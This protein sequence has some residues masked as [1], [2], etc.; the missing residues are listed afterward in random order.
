MTFPVPQTSPE[1]LGSG[2][3]SPEAIMM[4]EQLGRIGGVVEGQAFQRIREADETKLI[5]IVGADIY[6]G[7]ALPGT[8]ASE[9]KWK[10]SRINT[11][12]PISIYWADSSTLYNKVWNDRT[13]YTYA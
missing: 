6:I 8:L 12:N 4:W 2:H 7:C 10:I 9:S 3:M 11:N 13:T 1:Q 5:D